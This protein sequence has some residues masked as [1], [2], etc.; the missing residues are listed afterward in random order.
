MPVN[1]SLISS[2]SFV[3][4]STVT[5]GRSRRRFLARTH[6]VGE[7]AENERSGA[8]ADA[9]VV[10]EGWEGNGEADGSGRQDF[11]HAV[12]SELQRR[13]QKLQFLPGCSVR[14]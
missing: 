5:F 2:I 11:A 13:S 7:G 4:I 12:W 1:R 3:E 10:G 6:R 9:P 14:P 8:D